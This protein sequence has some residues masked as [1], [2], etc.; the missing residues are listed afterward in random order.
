MLEVLPDVDVS[1]DADRPVPHRR[2]RA[3]RSTPTIVDDVL[4]QRATCPDAVRSGRHDA[5]S[6][7]RLRA[8]SASALDTSTIAAV[9]ARRGAR[10]CP[11]RRGRDMSAFFVGCRDVLLDGPL[12]PR[13]SSSHARSPRSTSFNVGRY[14]RRYQFE[15][16]L[17]SP[18]YVAQSPGAVPARTG[19]R[20]CLPADDP[21]RLSR[22]RA[23][24]GVLSRRRAEALAKSCGIRVPFD[25]VSPLAPFGG[26]WIVRPEAL[27]LLSEHGLASTPTTR[28]VPACRG[29]TLARRRRSGS[30]PT[31]C[32]ELGFHCRTVLTAEHAGISHT[33]LEFKLDQLSS[34]TPGYP[35]EQIQF[36]HRAGRDGRGRHR[37]PRADVRAPEPSARQAR[38]ARGARARRAA[39]RSRCATCRSLRRAR[40][41]EE[42]DAMTA[43][44]RCVAPQVFPVGGRRLV[45]YV[46][47]GPAGRGRGLTSRTRLA[48]SARACG[49][50]A[51]RR[52][53]LADRRTGRAKLEPVCGRDPRPGES[54]ASTSGR[55]RHALDHLGAG[56]AEFDEVMLTNDTWFGP[57]RPFGPVFERMD[58]RAVHFWGMTDHAREEPNPFTRQGCAAV[59]PAVVLDRGAAARCSCSEAWAAYWR[60]LPQMPELLRCRAHARGGLH[61]ALH[62]PRLHRRRRI[63]LRPTTTPRTRRSS[64]PMLLLRRRMPDAQAPAAL[65]VAAV[66]RP[67][68]GHRPLD[69]RDRRIATAIP[70]S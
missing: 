49:A 20:R 65:P 38:S 34:T 50:D 31:R 66:P 48:R 37:G 2:D 8:R 58:A 47:V 16:L 11:S 40:A 26:M 23:A 68:R 25:D 18:G 64:T 14:F 30:S 62:R 54:S 56:I 52:Q 35:V 55:T 32:G 15:N 3:R 59:S 70:S 44:R 43:R 60:D 33:A 6:R 36:L 1:Y 7:H 63:P 13:R 67:A 22:P 69:A 4:A 57:V 61:G 29:R 42:A 12:R 5:R 17:S 45:I 28:A 41:S 10:R 27:R 39:A 9:R 51:R 19:P 24:A 21:H 46:G 53:R